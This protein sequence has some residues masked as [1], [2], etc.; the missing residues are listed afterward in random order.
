MGFECKFR[1]NLVLV[2]LLVLSKCRSTAYMEHG[3]LS[4]H[5]SKFVITSCIDNVGKN[6]VQ[7][8]GAYRRHQRIDSVQN[9]LFNILNET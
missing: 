3:S 4:L 7:F 9:Y 2:F 1:D 8:E 5:T 6:C